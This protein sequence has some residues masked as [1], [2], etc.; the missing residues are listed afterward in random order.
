MLNKRLQAGIYKRGYRPY[1]NP[2]F[3]VKK[4]DRKH[5][6]VNA[7]IN[8][9]RVTIRDANLPPN[10]DEFSEGLAG[11]VISSL[12]DFF[13]RYNQLLLVVESRDLTG[14]QIPL[15][16]LRITSVPLGGTNSVAQFVRVVSRILEKHFPYKGIAFLDDVAVKGARTTYEDKE[17]L[18]GVRKY[19]LEH[20]QQLNRVLANFKRARCTIARAKSQFYMPSIKIVGF[21]YNA[22]GRYL[23]NG[24][25]T[26]IIEQQRYSSLAKARGFI[27]IYVYYR[28][29][30]KDFALIAEPIFRLLKKDVQF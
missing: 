26:S 21:F 13:S 11:Y 29:Q 7:A 1:R 19:M 8:P 2:W 4:K 30:I 12:L 9:N 24:K 18:L 28:I 22:R 20:I 16:L 17:A 27:S 5:R 10:V 3:L 15:G 14:F 25:V 6:L 23:D